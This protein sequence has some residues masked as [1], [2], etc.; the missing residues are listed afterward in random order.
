MNKI[1]S[2]QQPL[3][4]QQQLLPDVTVLN[5]LPTDGI[6]CLHYLHKQPLERS[7]E[8]LLASTSWDGHVRIHN[9]SST[10]RSCVL[11]YNMNSGPLFDN[12]C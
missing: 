12:K 9:T 4:Q 5:D 10:N 1:E 6:T 11:D 2:S 7:D 3:Q 8:E